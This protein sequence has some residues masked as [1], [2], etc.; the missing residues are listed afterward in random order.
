MFRAFLS[1]I[2]SLAVATLLFS[3]SFKIRFGVSDQ[4]VTITPALVLGVCSI[5]ANMLDRRLFLQRLKLALLFALLA[6]ASLY[7]FSLGGLQET[8]ILTRILINC[9]LGFFIVLFP[10][11]R[12]SVSWLLLVLVVFACVLAVNT[13]MI[14]DTL[15]SRRGYEGEIREGYLNVTFAAAVGSICALYR[16][17]ERLD[18]VNVAMFVLCWIGT[19]LSLGRG[20][21]LF[22]AFVSVVYLFAALSMTVSTMG[23]AKKMIIALLFTAIAPLVFFQAMSVERTAKRLTTLFTDADS[24]AG[25]SGR[26]SRYEVALADFVERPIFG[27]GMGAYLGD[28]VSSLGYPH[29]IVLQYL[30][31]GGLIG[32]SII[33]FFLVAILMLVRA[34]LKLGGPEARNIVLAT[35]ALYLL[36]LLSY[37][38]SHDAYRGLEMFILSALPIATYLSLRLE[39]QRLR[40]AVRR[41]RSRPLAFGVQRAGP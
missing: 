21:L 32:G 7:S 25:V 29:N 20:A 28:S 2:V 18:P 37:M 31:D 23:R 16:I 1:A 9:S 35:G 27:N 39:T 33:V 17:I 40:R 36:M 10:W 22:G 8:A 11:N 14:Y 13:L 26:F 24:G 15:G 6:G 19:A 30:V 34:A 5:L 12:R 4:L 3:A 41:K 38:K